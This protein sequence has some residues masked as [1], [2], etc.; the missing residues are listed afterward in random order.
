M[1]SAFEMP[2]EQRD[3]RRQRLLLT[4]RMEFADGE[5]EVHLLN[6]SPTGAKLDCERAPTSGDVVTLLCGGSSVPGKVAWVAENRFGMAFDHPI[7]PALLIQ[8]GQQHLS[9]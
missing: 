5:R 2:E 7:D 9:G 3:N 4:A 6:L 1:A 8:R